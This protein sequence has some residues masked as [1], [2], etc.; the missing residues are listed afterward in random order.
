M[1]LTYFNIYHIFLFIICGIILIVEQFW[2]YEKKLLLQKRQKDKNNMHKLV[3]IFE[4]YNISVTDHFYDISIEEALS[5]V[6]EIRNPI[7]KKKIKRIIF[8]SE[9]NPRLR[10]LSDKKG[11]KQ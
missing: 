7:I 4:E 8:Y 9:L 1:E 2:E 11:S 10:S 3:N 5:S 6:E